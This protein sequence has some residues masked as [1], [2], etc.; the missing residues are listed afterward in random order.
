MNIC[1]GQADKTCPFSI[2][3]KPGI[4]RGVVL[5]IVPTELPKRSFC[6]AVGKENGF[7][8]DAA[9]IRIYTFLPDGFDVILKANC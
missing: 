4:S 1:K 3:T 8:S 6:A 2:G 7:K 5:D 9:K